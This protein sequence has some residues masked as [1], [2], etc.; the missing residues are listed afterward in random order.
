MPFG[1]SVFKG[2]DPNAA[3]HIVDDGGGGD[4]T[5]I[6]AAITAASAGDSIYVAPGTYSELVT[7]SKQLH[8]WG[9]GRGTIIKPVS[10]NSRAI[11]VQNA[12]DG[13]I[14]E[15]LSIN[16][17][18]AAGTIG[19][20]I[21]LADGT[22]DAD[23]VKEVTLRDI[24]GLNTNGI[25]VG[26]YAHHITLENIYAE[27]AGRTTAGENPTGVT[28]GTN[29]HDC[30]ATNIKCK[31]IY[32]CGIFLSGCYRI[33]IANP[34]TINCG[35]SPN[36]VSG[37]EAAYDAHDITIT[38]H[39]SL[40]DA[41]ALW[42]AGSGGNASVYRIK[43][44][45]VAMSSTLGS[46]ISLRDADEC[47]VDYIV[48]DSKQNGVDIHK[49]SYTANNNVARITTTL[50]QRSGAWIDG[51]VGNTVYLTSI[52]SSQATNNTYSDILITDAGGTASTNNTVQAVC[53]ATQSNKVKYHFEEVGT[54]D[55]NK[56]INGDF[57]RNAVTASVLK[58]GVGTIVRGNRGT[59]LVEE[60]DV[61]YA[62]NTSGASV[63]V[64]DIVVLKAVAA[65]NEFDDTTT[66]GDEKVF[67]MATATI[68]DNAWGY[69]Q[70][71]GKTTALKV[72]GTDDIAVGDFISTFSTAKIGQKAHNDHTAIAIALEAYT[73]DDS[74]GVIDALLIS[75]RVVQGGGV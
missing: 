50:A 56:I 67:G 29:A 37:I 2:K 71:A 5:T 42:L 35:D 47:V 39:T 49:V 19:K 51:G 60:S 28:F 18:R 57:D 15:K 43:A 74:A 45:G 59:T 25:Y 17:D 12:A 54:S 36:A 62:K 53:R 32:F 65:G 20:A 21:E 68:A 73:T 11:L 1:S 24:Y 64:G 3:D 61:T 22:E 7:V 30:S 72:D 63:A 10:T 31:D 58:V 75:P 13:T 52:D 41:R 66:Q 69:V 14:L 46:A 4:Y 23:A 6:S 40:N 33:S 9:A 55:N 70:T 27:A 48:N 8:I 26:N 38:N 16:D 34:T 44:D